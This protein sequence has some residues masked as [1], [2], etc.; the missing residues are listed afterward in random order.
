MGWE[1]AGAFLPSFFLCGCSCEACD[2]F[3]IPSCYVFCAFSVNEMLCMCSIHAF[4]SLRYAKKLV[5]PCSVGYIAS[6]TGNWCL[7]ICVYTLS[8]LCYHPL[9]GLSGPLLVIFFTYQFSVNRYKVTSVKPAS[10]HLWKGHAD[11]FNLKCSPAHKNETTRWS[12]WNC[13][14]I[15]SENVSKSL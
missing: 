12:N 2:Y 9:P 15:C 11:Q 7:M 6:L 1:T 8:G 13:I 5:L 14:T 3:Y 10:K 4:C